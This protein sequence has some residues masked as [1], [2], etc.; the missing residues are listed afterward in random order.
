MITHD[1]PEV[2]KKIEFFKK[3]C[4]VISNEWGIPLI[5]D[6]DKI[7]LIFWRLSRKT[8]YL[9]IGERYIWNY[10]TYIFF[11]KQSLRARANFKFSWLWS[12]TSASI[13][14]DKPYDWYVYHG[15]WI[16]ENK[17]R[18]PKEIVNI[19]PR[20]SEETFRRKFLNQVKGF[21]VCMENTSLIDPESRICKLCFKKLDC[22]K[23]LKINNP[24]LYEARYGRTK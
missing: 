19:N 7:N 3:C 14:F 17:L 15:K 16:S 2:E 9:S 12:N 13:W 11:S 4:K 21:I 24:E 10:V 5:L 18:I 20:A 6:D 22:K 23:L 1:L 8:H